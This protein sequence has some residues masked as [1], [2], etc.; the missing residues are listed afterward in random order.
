MKKT[1]TRYFN[2]Q[3]FNWLLSDE[4]LYLGAAA[5]QSDTSEGIYDHTILSHHIAN[6]VND[7]DSIA[8]KKLDELQLGLQ[9]VGREDNYLSCWYL[10]AEESQEMWDEFG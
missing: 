6:T 4:G 5:D 7:F 1:I 8:L 3:K 10:G 9:N 2:V